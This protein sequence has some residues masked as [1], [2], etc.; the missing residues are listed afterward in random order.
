MVNQTE[1]DVKALCTLA[2]EGDKQALQV[3]L[4]ALEKSG[5]LAEVINEKDARQMTPLHYAAR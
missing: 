5:R 4:V 3:K 1:V 2:T